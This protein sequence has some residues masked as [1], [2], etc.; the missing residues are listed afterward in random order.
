MKYA[1]PPDLT[2]NNAKPYPNP[3]IQTFFPIQ[4]ASAIPTI[5]NPYESERSIRDNNSG[6]QQISSLSEQSSISEQLSRNSSL[7][8][9]FR[10]SP[11]ATGTTYN[12]SITSTCQSPIYE[13]SS[14]SA[15]PQFTSSSF[16]SIPSRVPEPATPQ[17]TP[18]N[19]SFPGFTPYV[20][21]DFIPGSNLD[22]DV[23]VLG[24]SN[25]LT[26]SSEFSKDNISD[27]NIELAHK[28]LSISEESNATFTPISAAKLTDKLEHLLAEQKETSSIKITTV[29]S[30]EVDEIT[31]NIATELTQSSKPQSETLQ[32]IS[33]SIDNSCEAKLNDVQ[34]KTDHLRSH[35]LCDVFLGQEP[36]KQSITYPEVHT[37]DNSPVITD[38]QTSKSN[39]HPSQQYYQIQTTP[40]PSSTFYANNPENQKSSLNYV[41]PVQVS[42]QNSSYNLPRPAVQSAS[43][44][45]ESTTHDTG[46]FPAVS[47]Q[48]NNPN[49]SFNQLISD[50]TSNSQ[51]NRESSFSFPVIGSTAHAPFWNAD[52]SSQ[53]QP[54]TV[55]NQPAAPIFYNPAE[56]ANIVSKQSTLSNTYGQQNTSQQ[57]LY[58]DT[59][60][61]GNISGLQQSYVARGNNIACSSPVVPMATAIPES[62]GLATLSPVQMSVNS[63]TNRTT[64]DTVPPS[65]QNW[66]RYI[67]LIKYFIFLGFIYKIARNYKIK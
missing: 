43:A 48:Q 29:A 58:Q 49:T 36:A 52:Q 56:F 44:F 17:N 51:Q 4:N 65:F 31:S 55:S 50:T 46:H 14:V 23:T 10:S 16:R 64:S 8:G 67:L 35:T 41:A 20:N 21:R 39:T 57:Q 3:T 59:T 27:S 45:F 62:T 34:E 1:P 66:V 9:S 7:H 28:S 37:S 47:S 15:P 32:H 61:Y 19:V 5:L 12:S 54:L 11:V 13:N 40:V 24:S 60:C 30:S 25:Q 63:P 22:K 38:I 2:S 18:A 6:V 53:S 26:S 42:Q 33:K